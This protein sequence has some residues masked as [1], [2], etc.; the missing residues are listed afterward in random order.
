MSP[1]MMIGAGTIVLVLGIGLG[2]WIG[3]IGRGKEIARTAEVQAEL[4]D[5]RRQVSDHFKTT[6]VH[7][8][9]IGA[10]YRRLYEHMAAGAGSLCEM[11]PAIFEKPIEKIA[12]QEID[13]AAT[14]MPP[15]DYEET[16]VTEEALADEEPLVEEPTDEDLVETESSEELLAEHDITPEPVESEKTIH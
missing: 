6:A 14:M 13:E 5:Y 9:S 1:I 7:F 12:V 15:R 16:V 4:E 3:N 11:R 10:E 2:L 8:E